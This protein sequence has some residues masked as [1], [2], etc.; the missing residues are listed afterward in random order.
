M[1]Q[2]TTTPEYILVADAEL[3]SE[4]GRGVSFSTNAYGQ[5]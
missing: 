2:T 5:V 1:G 3:A 4:P